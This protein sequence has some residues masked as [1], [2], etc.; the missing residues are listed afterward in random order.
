[1][2]VDLQGEKVQLNFKDK[3]RISANAQAAVAYAVNKGLINGMSN[4]T[5]APDQSST[6]AQVASI[7]YRMMKLLGTI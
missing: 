1:M 5:F 4:N 3:D 6:R 7:L 2:K